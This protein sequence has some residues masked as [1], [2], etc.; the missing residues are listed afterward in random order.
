MGIEKSASGVGAPNTAD[1]KT[2]IGII[3]YQK[4]K[5]K[6]KE[7]TIRSIIAASTASIMTL[8]LVGCRKATF[9]SYNVSKEADNFNVLRKITVVNTRTD[10][11]LYELT[12]YF[13]LSNSNTNEIAVICCTG[14]DKYKKDF[15]YLNEWTTYVVE[16][17]D[18]NDVSPYHYELTIIP[19]S[20]PVIVPDI[21][22]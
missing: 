12:G 5:V 10:N 7:S 18:G 14:E 2:I 16:D 20:Y 9:A 22:E 13:S 1:I 21:E 3:S 19:K 4:G 8:F 11:I 15:I 17:L 6:M